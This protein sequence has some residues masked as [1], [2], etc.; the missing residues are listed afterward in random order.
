MHHILCSENKPPAVPNT[1]YHYFPLWW[2]YLLASLLLGHLHNKI[3]RSMYQQ[4][5][6]LLGGIKKFML[7]HWDTIQ[8]TRYTIRQLLQI[9]LVECESVLLNKCTCLSLKDILGH[10]GVS[11]IL[12]DDFESSSDSYITYHSLWPELGA[13]QPICEQALALLSSWPLGE[14]CSF[15][16]SKC[17]MEGGFAKRVACSDGSSWFQALLH[18]WTNNLEKKSMGP[19]LGE[20][21]QSFDTSVL[22]HV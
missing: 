1:D 16:V 17:K 19:C 13:E 14:E 5:R 3:S 15:T 12:V 9:N 20:T 2:K 18:F 6:L 10:V 22:L 7:P 21:H 8:N 11:T 4:M